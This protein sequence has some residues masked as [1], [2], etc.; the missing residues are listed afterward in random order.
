MR[1]FQCSRVSSMVKC[2][3]G[4][5]YV[6]GILDTPS[7]PSLQHIRLSEVPKMYI[8]HQHDVWEW[9]ALRKALDMAYVFHA[10]LFLSY[11][12]LVF[13]DH[14]KD[15]R[16]DVCAAG[17][18]QQ[19]STIHYPMPPV[20]RSRDSW[21]IFPHHTNIVCPTTQNEKTEMSNLCLCLR[22]ALEESATHNVH[23]CEV[24]V[25]LT[26]TIFRCCPRKLY[27]NLIIICPCAGSEV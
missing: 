22:R 15:D 2:G 7:L 14:E 18:H 25:S 24:F 3:K 1:S 10:R 20:S 12:T 27:Q 26:L 6:S 19:N 9:P 23:A 13:A 5:S 16:L 4:C 8:C 21:P 17:W 11:R